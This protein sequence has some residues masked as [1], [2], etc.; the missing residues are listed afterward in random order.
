MLNG[1]WILNI[2][3]HP[4]CLRLIT[5]VY[6]FAIMKDD[7]IG[8]SIACW[9]TKDQNKKNTVYIYIFLSCSFHYISWL[10]VNQ[11]VSFQLFHNHILVYILTYTEVWRQ[12]ELLCISIT[13]YSESRSYHDNEFIKTWLNRDLVYSSSFTVFLQ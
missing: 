1:G 2:Y 11:Y 3:F 5:H 10:N 8:T 13:K 6:N 12:H 7:M 9:T 4:Q